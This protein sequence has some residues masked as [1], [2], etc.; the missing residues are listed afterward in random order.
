VALPLALLLLSLPGASAGLT[1]SMCNHTQI[2]CDCEEA[3]PPVPCN[4]SAI[5]LRGNGTII[6]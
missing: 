3:S 1:A 6:D 2:I 4:D 5:I